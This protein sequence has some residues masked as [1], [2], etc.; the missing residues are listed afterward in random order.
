MFHISSLPLD[1]LKAILELS[2]GISHPLGTWLPVSYSPTE[3][4]SVYGASSERHY[5]NSPISLLKDM[6]LGSNGLQNKVQHLAIQVFGMEHKACFD[7]IDPLAFR[8]FPGF[9][10]LF[11]YTCNAMQAIFE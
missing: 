3:V 11:C 10:C 8:Q 5:K 4:P 6:E 7:L 9:V 2:Q 1:T